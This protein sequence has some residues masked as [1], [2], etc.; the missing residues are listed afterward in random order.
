MASRYR[1]QTSESKEDEDDEAEDIDDGDSPPES[2][3]DPL[4]VAGTLFAIDAGVEVILSGL[5]LHSSP[6]LD[7]TGVLLT[8]IEVVVAV[9][10]LR[11]RSR[12]R[13]PGVLL[14]LT[15]FGN[16]SYSAWLTQ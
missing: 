1:D 13:W 16:S 11:S 7:W 15:F 10:L 2:A 9:G 4:K 5:D 8:S 12:F 3:R 6:Q 14:M